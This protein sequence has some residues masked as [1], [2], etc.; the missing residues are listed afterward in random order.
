MEKV[1]CEA[2]C[3]ETEEGFKIEVKGE[4]A[5][6]ILKA[7]KKGDFSCCSFGKKSE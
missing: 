6:E 1:C 7:C 2:K 5:K 4:Y 3:V